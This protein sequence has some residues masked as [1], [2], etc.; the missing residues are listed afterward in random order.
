MK[1]KVNTTNEKK[2]LIPYW[3]KVVIVFFFGWVALYATRTIL[4]PIMGDI[5]S[6]F[7]LSKAQLGLIS[8]I[9]FI[10]Y[11]AMN[12]P[13]GIL[14]D[15][16]G[17]KKVLVP[18]VILFGTLAAVTG[19]MPTFFLFISAWLMVGLAQGVY[20]GPQYGISSEIIPKNRL[21]LGSAVINAGMA[22]G[23][24]IGYYISSY[25]VGEWGFGWRVPFFVIAVPVVII[26]IAMAIVVKD[27][28]K[29]SEEVQSQTAEPFKFSSLFNRNLILAYIIIF[30]SIY[31]FFM[32]ITWL[33]YYLETAR[34]L[35]GGN[36]AFVASLVPWAAIPGSLFFSWL[37]DKWG[38]RKPVLLMMLP[39]GILSTASIV[40]F[41]SMPILYITLIV[42]G[43]VGKISVNPVLIAVVANNAPRQ[44]LG[45]AFGFY[46]FV[47]ML[48]SIL[49]PY[50]TGWLTDTTGSMN[51]GFYF[52]AALLI[53]AWIAS[54]LIDESHL[55]DTGKEAK[56]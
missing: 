27:K 22:F 7:S 39:F 13:A 9:F 51:I 37:S 17:K 36:I 53:I 21:T 43:I 18:G 34:G 46:N 35:T 11:A 14:G 8:S 25:V 10:G 23:T 16:I 42:Y 6:A 44:S 52:A 5:E 4:N 45:T 2:P 1:N 49:A 24:S 30:C 20:Y 12:V 55:P 56:A 32:I 29:T 40:Y 26:G 31:G 33:P 41:D 28:P 54:S 38:R 48:G 15:K 3:G 19:M 47:G 50:I